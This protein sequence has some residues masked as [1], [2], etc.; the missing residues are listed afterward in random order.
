M[1]RVRLGEREPVVCPTLE[2][3]NK[4]RKEPPIHIRTLLN[5]LHP[6]KGFVYGRCTLEKA[7]GAERLV[8][9]VRPRANGR[10]R[11]SKCGR[12]GARYGSMPDARLFLFVPLWGVAFLLRYT[13]RRVDCRRCGVAVESVPWAEGKNTCTHAMRLF[14]ASWARRLSWKETARCFG[15]SWDTVYR[16]VRWVVAYGLAHRDLDGIEALGVDEVAYRKGHHYMTL[17]YQIDRGSRRLL[18]IVDGRRAKSLLRFF[19]EFGRERCARVKVVCSDMWKPYLKVVA[20]KLPGALNVLDPFHIA[21]KLGE[22]VDEIRRTEAREMRR[23]G[24]EP[25]LTG[26]RYCFLKRVANLTARQSDKLADLLRYDLRTVRA[27]CLKEAFAPF[28]QYTSA[29]WARWYLRKW[30]ARTMRSRLDPMK[31][32]VRTLR[33][34]E[35]LLMNYFK[36]GKHYNSGIVEGLNLRINLS[37]RKAYGYKSLEVLKVAL[38]H[39]LG[40]LSEPKATHRFC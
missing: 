18:G 3:A 17:I 19:R 11:C 23:D 14:L 4:Q 32:F 21:K 12:P 31:K 13:M 5:K 29:H 2:F 27:Y 20:K 36:A 30:C 15:S 38:F 37:M 1:V 39:Q 22:A 28:W 6:I 8:V 10:P 34:H 16:A 33:A 24:Y 7:D 9:D 35:D 25:V 40:E 26:S